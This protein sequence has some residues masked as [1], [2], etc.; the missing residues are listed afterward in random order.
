MRITRIKSHIYKEYISLKHIHS[1]TYQYA[2]EQI[3][4]YGR[5]LKR[6][7]KSKQN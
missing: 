2:S 7:G 3:T 1:N 4:E 6:I 5:A